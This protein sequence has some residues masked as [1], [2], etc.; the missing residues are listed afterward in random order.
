[1]KLVV[2]DAYEVDLFGHVFPVEKYRLT[3]EEAMRRGIVS[4]TDLVEARRASAEEVL[5]I[6]TRE[7]FEDFI[8][9]RMTHR[10]MRSEMA[11]TPEIVDSFM[12]TAGGTIAAGR[13]ALR[14]GISVHIGGGFHHA[15]PD[16]A[17]GFCY[18]ND[19]AIAIAV[20]RREEKIKRACVIDCDLHQGNGTAFIF[21]QDPD[22]FTFSIHQENN[23][24]P[25]ER[26]DLDIGLPDGAG[27]EEY[28][29]R[30]KVTGEI[31]H[32]HRPSI[33]FYLAGADP[34]LKDKLGGLALSKEG[35]KNRDALVFAECLKREIPVCAVFAGG[36]AFDIADDVD[37]HVNT[38]VEA[39]KAEREMGTRK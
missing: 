8:N 39:G 25:K 7:Y 9:R 28:L 11:L 6:H 20:L 32:R 30:L 33:V 3:R 27:D 31:L 12:V 29:S 17:E 15:Y 2:S 22:V 16:H 35:L 5:L 24:P 34:Y 26:S 36:Y 18:L 23:Y 14:D 13:L 1:M 19:V 37:I 21:S 10:T 38:I 4:E